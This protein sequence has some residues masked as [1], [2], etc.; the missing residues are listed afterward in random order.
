MNT[1]NTEKSKQ[2]MCEN[3]PFTK[4]CSVGQEQNLMKET[5]A[6]LQ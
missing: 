5:E 3:L 2:L 4:I 1:S 6:R